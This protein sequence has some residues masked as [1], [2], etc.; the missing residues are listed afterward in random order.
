[1]T[2]AAVETSYPVTVMFNPPERVP[3]WL[4]LL[5]WLL[6]I[7]HF[8][9]L[10]LVGI[11]ATICT[12][13]AWFAGVITGRIPTGLLGFIAGYHRYQLRIMTYVYFMRGAYPSF[14][15]SS[16]MIDPRTDPMVAIDFAPEEKRSRLTIFF[17]LFLLIPQIIVLYIVSIAA[18]VCSFIAWFAVIILGRWPSG[19][20]DFVLGV[21]R[22]STRVSAYGSLL[23]DK[24]PPFS[25]S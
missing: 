9:V 5:W 23:T 6:A 7:P 2:T 19:L 24:Y 8:I 3:R 4:P 10:Y 14:A 17:R 11:A 21:L 15:L 13:I 25:L 16:E 12:I 20:L 1:M 18:A 22:W